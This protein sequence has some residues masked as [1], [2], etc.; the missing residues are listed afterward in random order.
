ML[1]AFSVCKM[2]S[3]QAQLP[4]KII[5][6]RWECSGP[7]SLG[8]SLK[9]IISEVMIVHWSLF[10]LQLRQRCE[11]NIITCSNEEEMKRVQIK[12]KDWSLSKHRT[13]GNE[14]SVTAP[15]AVLAVEVSVNA[16]PGSQALCTAWA[17]HLAFPDTEYIWE[18]ST[19]ITNITACTWQITHETPLWL[20]RAL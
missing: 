18:M 9:R 17:R 12:S 10:S 14:H 16:R 2:V 19:A 1:L 15:L 8:T 6:S 11:W 4:S 7:K 20:Y 5:F 3:T 13:D